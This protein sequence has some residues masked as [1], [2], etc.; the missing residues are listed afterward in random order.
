MAIQGKY[1]PIEYLKQQLANYAKQ[2]TPAIEQSNVATKKAQ[3]KKAAAEQAA[4]KN[5]QTLNAAKQKQSEYQN[6]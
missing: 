3:E 6:G 5:N 1:D 4:L 2:F